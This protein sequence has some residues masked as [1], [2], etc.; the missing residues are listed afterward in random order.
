MLVDEFIL[1]LKIA[2]SENPGPKH[3]AQKFYELRKANVRIGIKI[4][5]TR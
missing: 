2:N 5:T 4:L 3:P 1:V